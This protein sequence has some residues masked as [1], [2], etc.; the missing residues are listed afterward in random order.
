MIKM[1]TFKNFTFL[2]ISTSLVNK[3][4][5]SILLYYNIQGYLA[6][7]TTDINFWISVIVLF[8][9]SSVVF[10][11]FD[12]IFKNS[13][14]YKYLVSILLCFLTFHIFL[15]ISDLPEWRH[16]RA[17]LFGLTNN[18]YLILLWYILP[19]IFFSITNILFRSKIEKINNFLI[20]LSLCF[21][22]IFLYRALFTSKPLIDY[23]SLEKKSPSMIQKK[24]VW[25][26]FD[27]FD[28]K[29]YSKVN[30]L[31]NFKKFSN[32][33]LVITDMQA[34]SD[35]T[36]TAIPEILTGIKTENY[37]TTKNFAELYL[38][39]G[40]N[41][42]I[43]FNFENSIFGKIYKKGFT[44]SIFGIYHPYCH[45][46]YQVSNCSNIEFHHDKVK[47][48]DGVK[49]ILFL[50]LID[51][52]LNNRLGVA[53]DIT[54]KQ[55][56]L[57]PRHIESKDNLVFMHFGFP[58]LPSL[59]AERIYNQKSKN[60]EDSYKL[61][62]KLANDV[63]GIITDTLNKNRLE[64]TLIILSSDHWLRSLE[65]P[66][67][68]LFNA[69]IINDNESF[70]IDDK[71]SNYYISELVLKYFNNEIKSNKDIKNFFQ[72]KPPIP[73]KYV[74]RFSM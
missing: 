17:M 35:A 13:I 22:S 7:Q 42:K 5:F 68:V 9:F 57:I 52:F 11:I 49:H 50:N 63:L 1:F 47:W 61:N 40:N 36:I 16:Y 33:S 30:N 70:V 10:Y 69:K 65:G 67:P 37:I 44:S 15:D 41:K 62:L 26:L 8:S 31:E 20:I 27:E 25:I 4:V 73:T 48:Y 32:E 3:Y 51:K 28:Y 43:K 45:I 6:G 72:N 55:I 23:Y 24:A 54:K 29:F 74:P 38:I 18:K 34:T 60:E 64:N 21:F 66:R 58:H 39:D 59:Y 71:S 12:I 14:F 2:G 19:V 46:F 53:S 56:D